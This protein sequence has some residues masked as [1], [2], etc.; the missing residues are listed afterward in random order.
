MD[1]LVNDVA[2]V[3]A[4]ESEDVG[5]GGFIGQSAEADAVALRAA[6]DELLGQHQRSRLVGEL[7]NKWR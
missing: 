1:A 3:L 2:S 5:D 7:R 6:R 4:E